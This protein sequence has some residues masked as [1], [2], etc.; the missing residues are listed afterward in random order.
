[1]GRGGGCRYV[2]IICVKYKQINKTVKT[3]TIN[4]NCGYKVRNIQ[5][6]SD[7]EAHTQQISTTKA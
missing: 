5:T 4:M 1:M 6:I 3:R 2:Q 7:N